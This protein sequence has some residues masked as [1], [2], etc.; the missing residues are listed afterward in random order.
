LIYPIDLAQIYWI[1]YVAVF[2]LNDDLDQM[3]A[4]EGVRH[5]V[6]QLYV[7]MIWRNNIAA[8]ERHLEVSQLPTKEN[9]HGNYECQCNDSESNYQSRQSS[10]HFTFPLVPR[11]ANAAINL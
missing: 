3:L 1:K 8:T 11:P 6:I 9:G 5:L 4:A 7:F 2:Y 10:Y